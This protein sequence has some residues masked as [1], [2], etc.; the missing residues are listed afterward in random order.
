V[1]FAIPLLLAFPA[2]AALALL[3]LRQRWRV[4]AWLSAI[5]GATI[6]VFAILAGAYV[7]TE[8]RAIEEG[9]VF[10]LTMIGV[11]F[12]DLA[13]LFALMWLPGN[14]ANDSQPHETA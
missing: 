12:A 10:W 9:A 6:G 8:D 4:V 2:V 11:M 5:Y 14:D 13:G 3:A 1:L 7:A